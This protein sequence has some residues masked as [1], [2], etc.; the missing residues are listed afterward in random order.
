MSGKVTEK[1][2]YLL[3]GLW[4]YSHEMNKIF[5]DRLKE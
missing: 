1:A 5:V 2:D 4:F 3:V